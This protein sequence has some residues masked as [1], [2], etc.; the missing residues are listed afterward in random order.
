MP[1][2]PGVFG[3][4][5]PAGEGSE[6]PTPQDARAVP[7]QQPVLFIREQPG[8]PQRAKGQ[9]VVEKQLDRMDD[10]GVDDQLQH[11]VSHACNQTRL[12]PEPVAREADDEHGEQGD[13]AAEGKA[14]NLQVGEHCAQRDG[15]GAEGHLLGGDPGG[16]ALFPFCRAICSG[17]AGEGLL[18]HGPLSGEESGCGKKRCQDDDQQYLSCGGGDVADGIP[19]FDNIVKHKK[20]SLH[21][22]KEER[23]RQPGTPKIRQSVCCC[24]SLRRYCPV[25]VVR[26]RDGGMRSQSQRCAP[27]AVIYV[28]AF[29]YMG[30]WF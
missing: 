18:R 14:V 22:A 8:E 10:I 5:D 30:F 15:H 4:E 19:V 3:E 2:L 12:Q 21:L 6:E 16:S 11:A 25:Q 27:L 23:H 17:S 7:L 13:G 1:S 26:V 20:S 28:F 24:A 9:Q 29:Y